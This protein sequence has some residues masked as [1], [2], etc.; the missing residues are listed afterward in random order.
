MRAAQCRGV[1]E[2]R[3]GRWAATR[4]VI[5]VGGDDSILPRVVARIEAL[6]Q[7]WSRFVDTSEISELNRHPGRDVE[8]S[9]ETRLLVQSRG[10]GVALTGGG[11]RSDGCS[12]T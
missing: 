1:H 5:V 3:S 11:L 6:E 12:A 10:R 4:H 2:S 9:V 8:V 7:R